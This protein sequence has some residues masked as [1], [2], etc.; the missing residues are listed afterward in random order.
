MELVL[1]SYCGLDI[2]L[3]KKLRLLERHRARSAFME[4]RRIS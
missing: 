4:Y 2:A 1:T 3:P